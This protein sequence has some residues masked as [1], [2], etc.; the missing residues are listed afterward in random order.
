LY[1]VVLSFSV[2]TGRASEEISLQVSVEN[3]TSGVRFSVQSE[4]V[5][6]MRVEIL[7]LNGQ[8]IFQ[9]TWQTDKTIIWPMAFSAN[10]IAANGVYLY[11]ITT[12][13]H[14]GQEHKK[15]GKLAL[16]SDASIGLN[17]PSIGELSDTEPSAALFPL[18]TG[19]F[20]RQRLGAD[21]SDTLR[22]QRKPG[23]QAGGPVT[24]FETLLQLEADGK[25]RL[26]ELCLGASFAPVT[27]QNPD[28]LNSEGECRT[29]WGTTGGGGGT[30]NGWVD[31]GL[32]VRLSSVADKVG[33]G[34]NSPTEKLTV[35]GNIDATGPMSKIS[36]NYPTLNDLPSASTYHGMLAHVHA[37]G[38]AYFAHNGQWIELALAGGE[39]TSPNGWTDEGGIVRLSSVADKVGIGTNNPTEKLT[40]AG[41]IDATGPMSKISFNYP[42]LNDLP[43]ATTYHG[44]LAHVHA[45]GKAYFAHGGQWIALA[46]EGSGGSVSG[47]SLTGNSGINPSTQFIGTTTNAALSFRTNNVEQM[48]LTTGGALHI[49]IINLNNCAGPYLKVI[50]FA[51]G[52]PCPDANALDAAFFAEDQYG[53][54]V[55]GQ[56]NEGPGIEGISN[57]NSGVLGFSNNRAGVK[58]I[59]GQR[60]ID[61]EVDTR[62]V[63]VAG[64]S[65][66]LTGA[67]VLGFN[68]DGPGVRGQSLK[69][70]GVYGLSDEGVG[71]LGFS[72]KGPGVVGL[73][74]SGAPILERRESGIIGISDSES[75]AGVFGFNSQGF[76]VHGQSEGNAGVYGESNL[77]G[78]I[79]F[80]E[81]G[82]GVQGI[83]STQGVIGNSANGVGVEGVSSNGFGIKG[84]SLG[85]DAGVYGESD[86]GPGIEG[87]SK[88]SS[89][90]IGR[91][92]CNFCAG[93]IGSSKL[94]VGVTGSSE[95]STGVDGRSKSGSYLFTGV[96]EGNNF[97]LRFGV[98]RATGHVRADGSFFGNGVDYADML[99]VAGRASDYEPGDVLV[100][101][102]DGKLIKSSQ[103]YA[104][105][106]AGVYSTK[107]AF[108]GDPRGLIED[109]THTDN[110]FVPVAL[111]GLVPVKVSAEN[112]P[113]KP[114]DLL[115]TASI[116]GYAMKATDP[117]IGT[118]LGKAMQ[119]LEKGTGVINVLVTLR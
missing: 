36:F 96:D 66:A 52:L 92:T 88:N 90:V 13:D 47:W 55:L 43:S 93:V 73:F 104:T 59:S 77:T 50:R 11:T 109:K 68:E 39:G 19:T 49:G 54:A 75:G 37:T 79:G 22:L 35:A 4:D 25:L 12:R 85:N 91:A 94:S 115:T 63:G 32:S 113:I 40:V 97:N 80:S 117:K 111:V 31:D 53:R 87:T 60:G 16:L 57:T 24:N 114:G 69:S 64:F 76:G 67:G 81:K 102:P 74:G 8:L 42:T 61:A 58:G 83:G 15:L 100:I 5:T 70:S 7:S 3:H 82:T 119:S 89:A 116:P 14:H 99:A 45:T 118:V 27:A 38:K 84:T 20:W 28:N 21:K 51:S 9:S 71:I 103:S 106:L 29:T 62:G 44:M 26:K 56:S 17:L 18:P 101:G 6:A 95:A 48:R 33:I 1:L 98:E 86:D 65:T 10:R 112:G 107:P 41:N 34:T 105:T 108:V 30:P 110:N 78:V 2:L 72:Q 46:N 23:R